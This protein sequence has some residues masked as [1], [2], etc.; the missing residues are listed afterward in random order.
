[1]QMKQRADQ[2]LPEDKKGEQGKIKVWDFKR[3]G[4]QFV[5]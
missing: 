2:L 1:M 3:D 5:R 4:R